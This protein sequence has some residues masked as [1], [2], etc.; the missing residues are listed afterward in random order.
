MSVQDSRPKLDRRKFLA[1]AAV[2]GTSGA[3]GPASA[4]TATTPDITTR[5]V[6]ALPPNSYVAA[7]ESGTPQLPETENGRPG[8][9]FMVDVI[10]TFDIKYLP[11]NPAASYRGL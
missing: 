5:P 7:N 8:S 1:A 3:V 9:D 2:A 10:K 4:T 11:A 6:S